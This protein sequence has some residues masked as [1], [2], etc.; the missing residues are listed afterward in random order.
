MTNRSF[1][2]PDLHYEMKGQATLLQ[3]WI[4][5]TISHQRHLQG[6]GNFEAIGFIWIHKHR[7]GKQAKIRIEKK[8]LRFDSNNN[9][10]KDYLH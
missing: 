5:I 9:E 8:K 1:P 7:R 2:I 4:S 10:R 6:Q 3:K